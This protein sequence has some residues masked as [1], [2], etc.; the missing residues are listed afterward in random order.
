MSKGDQL[1]QVR[2]RILKLLYDEGAFYA[3]AGVKSQSALKSKVVEEVKEAGFEVSERDIEE[4]F[5]W[6]YSDRLISSW[7]G[8]GREPLWLS[9]EGFKEAR[10]ITEDDA[11][12]AEKKAFYGG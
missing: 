5:L 10:E 1:W 4:L 7:T 11:K 3:K 9:R 2:N 8:K 6:L 12:L